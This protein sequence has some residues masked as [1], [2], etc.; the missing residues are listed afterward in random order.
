MLDFTV[1][2]SITMTGTANSANLTVSD[3]ILD[4]QPVAD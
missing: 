4:L 3:L 1:S 2:E